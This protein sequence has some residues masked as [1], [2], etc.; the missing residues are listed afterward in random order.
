[1]RSFLGITAHVVSDFQLHSAVLACSRFHGS[2]TADS[3]FSQYST[4]VSTYEINKSVFY[5]V[6]DNAANM[7]KAFSFMPDLTDQACDDEDS[8]DCELGS[9]PLTDE[10]DPPPP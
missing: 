2:H 3:I 1:M 5:L 6:T 4:V 8:S 9:S 10:L 7:V